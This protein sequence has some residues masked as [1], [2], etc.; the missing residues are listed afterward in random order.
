[1]LTKQIPIEIE[2]VLSKL[3]FN[4][5]EDLLWQESIAVTRGQGVDHAPFILKLWNVKGHSVVVGIQNIDHKASSCESATA[6]S[7]WY[8]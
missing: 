5:L 7:L 3:L 4:G 6:S 2:H 8:E 1:M